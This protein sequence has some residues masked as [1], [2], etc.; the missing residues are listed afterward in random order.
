MASI[1]AGVI[2][3]TQFLHYLAF[4]KDFTHFE[5]KL[6]FSFKQGSESLCQNLRKVCNK[7][8]KSLAMPLPADSKFCSAPTG[9]FEATY[10]APQY[11]SSPDA[12]IS[13]QSTISRCNPAWILVQQ[14]GF[15]EG[16]FR[17]SPKLSIRSWQTTPSRSKSSG[18][19]MRA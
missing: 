2:Q 14:V 4:V 12:V 13:R 11:F 5:Q 9:C 3:R 1:G 7:Y 10:C 6:V 8:L 19:C 17:E 16:A 15:S 18:I